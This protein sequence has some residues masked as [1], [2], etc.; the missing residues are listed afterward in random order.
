MPSCLY[1]YA[2][3]NKGG[4]GSQTIRHLGVHMPCSP[5]NVLCTPSDLC[6]SQPQS[7]R[8]CFFN[9]Q[10]LYGTNPSYSYHV[11][12]G[13]CSLLN[14]QQLFFKSPCPFLKVRIMLLHNLR[15][16]KQENVAFCCVTILQCTPVCINV[17]WVGIGSLLN[18]L[19]QN[20]VL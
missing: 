2:T 4:G 15:V 16:Y 5:G 8:T 13:L 7:R 9:E 1:C 17:H 14:T 10:Y 3:L 19:P 6:T 18:P 11:F 20:S 12:Y